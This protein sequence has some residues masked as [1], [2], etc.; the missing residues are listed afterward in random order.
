MKFDP[1]HTC[2]HEITHFEKE[3]KMAGGKKAKTT[4]YNIMDLILML[5]FLRKHPAETVTSL[6]I[7]KHQREKEKKKLFIYY[8]EK[9][10]TQTR[11]YILLLLFICRTRSASHEIQECV[12]VCVH[13]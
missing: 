11:I 12:Y 2:Q 8:F 13:V 1:F 10:E 9:F 3:R 5:W 6:F 7:K 4:N